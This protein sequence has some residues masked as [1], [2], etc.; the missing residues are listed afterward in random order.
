MGIRDDGGRENNT[1]IPHRLF[2]V[3]AGC[4]RQAPTPKGDDPKV[5]A[6]SQALSYRLV[7]KGKTASIMA[8]AARILLFCSADRSAG[9][10]CAGVGCVR[11]R[12]FRAMANRFF[13]GG[14]RWD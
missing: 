6:A 5:P 7:G 11:V 14:L 3:D 2:T 8:W 13:A 4:S 10:F 9:R 1:V 12:V